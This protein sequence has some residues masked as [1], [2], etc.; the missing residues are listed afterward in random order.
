MQGATRAGITAAG[1]VCLGL[2]IVVAGRAVAPDK[3]PLVAASD[4]QSWV[5]TED[6]SDSAA[7]LDEARQPASGQSAPPVETDTP[8][9]AGDQGLTR[10][11]PREP[12]SALS[13]ALPPPKPEI[14]LYHRPVA[15]A[16][17]R[18]EA[19]G[20]TLDIAGTES[21]EPTETC[22]LGSIAWDCG[23]RARTA[24]RLWLRGRSLSCKLSNDGGEQGAAI[25]S[26]GNEDVGAWL[27]SNG[28]ARAV[29]DGPYVEAEKQ[30]REARLGI[31]GPPPAALPPANDGIEAAPLG[32][33]L[34]L[35]D[36][37]SDQPVLPDVIN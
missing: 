20:Y 14:S 17:A 22:S 21:I 34:P 33:A 2:L 31:F 1:L 6:L 25:C 12:L 8:H 3:V 16:S 4:G 35:D 18:F 30:A 26:L 19:M 36:R 29:P 15:V 27:V 11:A 37:P 13:Q 24:V 10:E 5:E 32:D 28:W 23:M 9:R 7:V